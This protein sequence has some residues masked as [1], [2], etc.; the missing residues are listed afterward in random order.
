MKKDKKIEEMKEYFGVKT[1][2]DVAQRMGYSKTTANTWRSRGLSK[3][4]INKFELIKSN[5]LNDK[6]KSNDIEVNYYP[7][8]NASAGYGAQ[9]DTAFTPTRVTLSRFLIDTFRIT[10][11]A[12]VDLI[13]IYGAAVSQ[14]RD[15]RRRAHPRPRSGQKRRHRHRQHRRRHLHQAHREDPLPT[16]DHPPQ[17]Q[18]SLRR[19]LPRCR[20]AH[21]AGD[22]RHRPRQ[23]QGDLTPR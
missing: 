15:R 10:D 17:Q 19:H 6:A 12:A 9:N 13:H 7:E 11:T 3:S 4:A 5:D 23:T 2:E 14:R 22:R 1:I 20:P 16:S 8:I 18:P 21:P